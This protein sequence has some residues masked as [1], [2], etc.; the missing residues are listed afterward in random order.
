[1]GP[2]TRAL[3]CSGHLRFLRDLKAQCLGKSPS[4][5]LHYLLKA[6]GYLQWQQVRSASTAQNTAHPL[7]YVTCLLLWHCAM[8]DKC[9][10]AD[11]IVLHACELQERGRKSP[12]PAAISALLVRLQTGNVPIAWRRMLQPAACACQRCLRSC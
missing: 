11:S 8:L 12:S 1:M 5:A 4:Q 2:L 9:R 10:L 3:V 6:S 7:G